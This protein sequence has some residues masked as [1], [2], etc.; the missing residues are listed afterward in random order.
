MGGAMGMMDDQPWVNDYVERMMKDRKYVE[1]AYNR[2]Q[3]QKVFEWA[4]TKVKPKATSIKAE[5]FAKM[6]SEHQHHH[7]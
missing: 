2:L 1:D 6:V 4:E 5:D 3:S 7:H